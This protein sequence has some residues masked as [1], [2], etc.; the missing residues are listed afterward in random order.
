MEFAPSARIFVFHCR[1]G[2]RIKKSTRIHFGCGCTEVLGIVRKHYKRRGS[3][4]GLKGTA[5]RTGERV[6][7]AVFGLVPSV[8][9]EDHLRANSA[10]N[11]KDLPGDFPLKGDAPKQVF[12]AVGVRS[13]KIIS[14]R[15]N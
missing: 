3:R 6:H 9:E 11:V 10:G 2:A 4:R 14:V 15:S 12:M 1:R 13:W 5:D 7:V 8:W